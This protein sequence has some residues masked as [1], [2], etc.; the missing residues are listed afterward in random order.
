MHAESWLVHLARGTK[1]I[2]LHWV[3]PCAFELN[4]IP[5]STHLNVLPFG[6]YSILMCMDWLYLHGTKV[7]FYDNAIKCLDDNEE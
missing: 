1:K 5:T 6:S 7:D 4:G 2:V 3:R